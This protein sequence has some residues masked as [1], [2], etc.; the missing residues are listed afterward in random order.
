MCCCWSS[1][2]TGCRADG[3]AVGNFGL[4]PAMLARGQDR[5]A[6]AW[7][8][9]DGG[10]SDVTGLPEG[11]HARVDLVAQVGVDRILPRITGFA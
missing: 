2:L 5:Q 7:F 6:D 8:I 1:G 10:M 4:T 9:I 3:F 11:E